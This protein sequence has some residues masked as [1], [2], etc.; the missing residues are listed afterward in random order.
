[1]TKLRFVNKLTLA[2]EK[3]KN[4]SVERFGLYAGD[5][6]SAD[7]DHGQEPLLVRNSVMTSA[8]WTESAGYDKLW[9]EI[10]AISRRV[11]SAQLP[12]Q[13]DIDALFAR[14][15][16]DVT[17]HR[18]AGGDLTT[19]IAREIVNP[20]FTRIVDVRQMLKYVGL[21]KEIAGTG[22]TVPLVDDALGVIDPVAMHIYAL[23][24]HSSISRDLF[25][26]L[27]D[28]RMVNEA[29]AEADVDLRNSKVIGEIVSKTYTGKQL[30][31]AVT[32][33]ATAR[34]VQMYNTLQA[35][36]KKLKLLIDPVTKDAIETPSVTILAN[37]ADTWD[38]QRVIGGNLRSTNT[39]GVVSVSTDSP[40]PINNLVEYN[41]GATHGKVWQKK[42][43]SYPGVEAGKAYLLV[44]K[45]KFLVLVKRGLTRETSKG[46]ALQLEVSDRQAWYRC[47]AEYS[48]NFLGKA[49]GVT[50]VPDGSGYILKVNLPT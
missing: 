13:E 18:Q 39:S 48:K 2:E 8:N 28:L 37:S 42:K 1:M 44:P 31:T 33:G 15:M 19:E 38:L 6:S 50:G 17:R 24:F 32:A 14:V 5:A 43:V 7:S 21:F 36:I 12:R 11:N 10:G 3:A 47:Q 41:H 35:A 30:Q 49:S 23:G 46:D 4:Q 9:D 26:H 34:D 45:E 16:L 25:N 29:V 27:D 40:L 22:D 20:N